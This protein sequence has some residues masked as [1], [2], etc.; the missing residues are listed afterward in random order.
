MKKMYDKTFGGYYVMSVIAGLLL[1]FA[2]MAMLDVAMI[3]A[4]RLASEGLL[5]T[6]D[7]AWTFLPLRAFGDLSTATAPLSL[8]MVMAAIPA[9]GI[10]VRMSGSKSGRT[11]MQQATATAF[12]AMLLMLA[13]AWVLHPWGRN[14]AL[15]LVPVLLMI[16]PLVTLKR[17]QQEHKSFSEAMPGLSGFLREFWNQC[18]TW[19]KVALVACVIAFTIF[20]VMCVVSWIIGVNLF[21]KQP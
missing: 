8:A 21:L 17:T 11:K 16:I 14:R 1:A 4:V 9:V 5:D 3:D 6:L 18:E 15:A 13:F 7:V 19:Q 20:M 2:V 12:L 10:F